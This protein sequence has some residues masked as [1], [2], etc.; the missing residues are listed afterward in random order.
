MNKSELQIKST[1]KEM[2][3]VKKKVLVVAAHPD[4]EVIGCG[5][6]ITRHRQSQ[7]E[8]HLLIFTDGVTSRSYSVDR[9]ISRAEELKRNK[10]AI[11]RRKKESY[12]AAK[13]LGIARE[14][15]HNLNLADQRLDIYP[16]LDLVKYIEEI[17]E[18][19]QPDVVYAHFWNDLNLDHRLTS[20]A[21]A[22][23][24]RLGG[25]GK[26]V[27]LLQF[28]VPE[29]TYLSI[30]DGKKAFQ[31]NY[32]VD[33]S[34]TLTLKLKALSAYASERRDYPELRSAQWIEELAR[35]R[36]K[37]KRMKFAEG[38]LELKRSL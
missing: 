37:I 16:F 13:V 33:I 36:G 35:Q 7:D 23:A 17:K 8:V 4:D 5:G 6:T 26:N 24:F 21:V 29:S 32:F 2:N 3:S 18:K 28:E 10:V 30:P 15:V 22:T 31:P 25:D 38:F 11:T 1:C 27:L 9:K 19:V 14:C 20:Q 12:A 34:E